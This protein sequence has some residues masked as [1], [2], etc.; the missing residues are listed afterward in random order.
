MDTEILGRN[1]TDSVTPS[2]VASSTG[3]DRAR[4][5]AAAGIVEVA[6]LARQHY[7]IEVAGERMVIVCVP[8]PTPA[9]ALATRGKPSPAGGRRKRRRPRNWI[10]SARRHH[11]RLVRTLRRHE[12]GAGLLALAM[13]LGAALRDPEAVI[14]ASTFLAQFGRVVAMF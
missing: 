7:V 4:E 1:N 2:T 3:A 8:P 11:S 12:V 5:L 14:A 9:D 10:Q 13:L 6:H